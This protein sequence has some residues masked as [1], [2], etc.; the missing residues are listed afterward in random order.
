M[1]LV[2]DTNVYIASFLGKQLATDIIRLAQRN[3]VELF[4][5]PDII[6][7]LTAT[8][9]RKLRVEED[10]IAEFVDLI[11]LCTEVVNPEEKLK[12]VAADPDDNAIVECAVAAKAHLIITMDK[13]LLKLKQYRHIGI[14]HPKTLTWIVPKL[15]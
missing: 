9:Q 15:L 7:E 14:V 8:L 1:R 2:L 3:K 4:I 13:H 11:S 10:L 5:S 6:E 12:V